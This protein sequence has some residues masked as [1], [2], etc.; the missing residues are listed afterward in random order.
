MGRHPQ[1]AAGFIK[2]TCTGTHVHTSANTCLMLC[3]HGHSC[4]R[5]P[6]SMH[7]ATHVDAQAS[8]SAHTHAHTHSQGGA[9][10]PTCPGGCWLEVPGRVARTWLS[11]SG[12]GSWG[13]QHRGTGWSQ[14]AATRAPSSG[15]AH[16]QG[17]VIPGH[18]ARLKSHGTRLQPSRSPRPQ[19]PGPPAL[20]LRRG[21][22]GVSQ[23][24]SCSPC[25]APPRGR[26]VLPPNPHCSPV[27]A[28]SLLCGS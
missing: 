11:A 9:S 24:Q 20:R 2:H 19:G 4:A 13:S 23:L 28:L 5:V 26:T 8:I 6:T 1:V 16:G 12:Q 21:A 22:G 7:T 17:K 27:Q 18:A 25:P 14:S 15:Q 10:V 3:T